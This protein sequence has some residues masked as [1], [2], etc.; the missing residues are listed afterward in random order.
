MAVIRK[1]LIS[2][3]VRELETEN[4]RLRSEIEATKR[5]LIQLETYR[6]LKQIPIPSRK[7]S[8]S[9]PPTPDVSIEITEPNKA[10]IK[11]TKKAPKIDK[12]AKKEKKPAPAAEVDEPVVDV[13]RLDMRIGVIKQVEKHP[14]ADSLYVSKIDCGEPNLRTVVSGLVKFVTKDQLEGR[15]VVLMCNL[16]PAKVISI[17]IGLE[18]FI[19]NLFV[20]RCVA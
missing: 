17:N 5:K 12:P 18:Y 16:K 20:L 1:E 7:Y 11:I 9:T 15:K 3:T 8:S 2:R 14:D 10:E 6:G 13:S 4:E 19:L